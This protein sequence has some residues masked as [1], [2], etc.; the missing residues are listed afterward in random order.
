MPS[1][2]SSDGA[3]PKAPIGEL[4]PMKQQKFQVIF[5]LGG[6]GAGKGTQ[7]AKILETFDDSVLVERLGIF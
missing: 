1:K 3:A 4:A 6:P 2:M 7:C 5:V